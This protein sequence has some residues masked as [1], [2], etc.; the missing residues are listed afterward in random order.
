MLRSQS[1]LAD[2]LP[3][4]DALWAGLPLLTCRGDSFAGRVAASLLI[5]IGVPEL[6]TE[7]LEEYQALALRLA[8]DPL[9][10]GSFR[11]RLKQNRLTY[12]LFDTDR[13]R[14]HLEAAFTKMWEL[15][16]RGERP[17]SFTVERIAAIPP[18]PPQ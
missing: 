4:L 5:A 17:R 3:S 12:P 6:I 8:K 11:H 9:L 15:W 18:R 10:L 7:N 13:Y 1:G 14:R 16:Q 2:I